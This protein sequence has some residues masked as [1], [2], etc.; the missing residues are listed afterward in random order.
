MNVASED[1]AARIQRLQWELA[2][3]F[4]DICRIV[5]S[6]K[7]Y[8]IEHTQANDADANDVNVMI[9]LILSFYLQ[10]ILF[11][12]Q[13][14]RIKFL[15]RSYP[16]SGVNELAGVEGIWRNPQFFNFDES[17]EYFVSGLKTCKGII[18]E[19]LNTINRNEDDYEVDDPVSE[20]EK[21][22]L[23]KTEGRRR[24]DKNNKNRRK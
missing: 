21:K 19:W 8:V 18:T 14:H 11:E 2:P 10:S 23:R 16:D 13:N 24:M 1:H 12:Y 9:T 17:L 15:S 3:Y 4:H 6:L 7:N 20:T 22:V 5:G